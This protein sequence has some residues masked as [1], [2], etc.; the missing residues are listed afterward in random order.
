M[1]INPL[2]SPLLPLLK[3]VLELQGQDTVQSRKNV[4]FD[5]IHNTETLLFW[6]SLHLWKHKNSDGARSGNPGRGIFSVDMLPDLKRETIS[7]FRK[8]WS[9]KVF[10]SIP[11]MLAAV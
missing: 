9:L 11:T 6:T 8:A 1:Y 10:R 2:A 5:F 3:T 4:F 7:D